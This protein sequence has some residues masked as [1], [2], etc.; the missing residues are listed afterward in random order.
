MNRGEGKA[1][2][3]LTQ[4]LV[5]SLRSANNLTA[6]LPAR[7]TTP[8]PSADADS[9]D[10]HFVRSTCEVSVPVGQLELSQAQV[11]LTRQALSRVQAQCRATTVD[12]PVTVDR[13]A[14][15]LTSTST[16]SALLPG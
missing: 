1:R 11:S 10:D 13:W 8:V 12:E 14:L 7:A 6:T 2:C 4:T 5:N 16:L 15:T 9:A 3:G